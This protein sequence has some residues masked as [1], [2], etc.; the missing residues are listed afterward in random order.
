MTRPQVRFR[1]TLSQTKFLGG[2]LEWACVASTEAQAM[3]LVEAFAS[4]TGWRPPQW[5]HWWR[6]QDPHAPAVHSLADTGAG[7]KR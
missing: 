1:A 3:A 6:R 7:H 2:A 4:A 5:W